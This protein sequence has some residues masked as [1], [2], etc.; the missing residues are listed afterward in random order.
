MGAVL[1]HV[2]RGHYPE[3]VAATRAAL[4][5]DGWR[6]LPDS[7]LLRLLALYE[8]YDAYITLHCAYRAM[9][10]SGEAL[11]LGD[12]DCSLS[13]LANAQ[14]WREGAAWIDSQQRKEA[15]RNASREQDEQAAATRRMKDIRGIRGAVGSKAIRQLATKLRSELRKASRR[16]LF[17]IAVGRVEAATEDDG[18][19]PVSV[20][21]VDYLITVCCGPSDDKKLLA[22]DAATGERDGVPVGYSGWKNLSELKI[23]SA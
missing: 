17:D 2:C 4:L 10:E 14:S 12:L 18:G 22:I 16:H 3:V 11:D 5:F 7:A 1:E 21:D 9:K 23:P 20:D 13:A 19:F 6:A 15:A 8:A